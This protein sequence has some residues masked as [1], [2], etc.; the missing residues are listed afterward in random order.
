MEKQPKEKNSIK[1][2]N[3][4]N[5]EIKDID[6]RD[7]LE[8]ANEILAENNYSQVI[9]KTLNILSGY[10]VADK[11]YFIIGD[12]NQSNTRIEYGYNCDKNDIINFKSLLIKDCKIIP[13]SLLFES[14]KSG[15]IISDVFPFKN[16][17]IGNNNYIVSNNIQ[18][19]VVNPISYQ[20]VVIGLLYAESE[21]QES[22]SKNF[23]ELIRLLSNSIG[24]AI[25]K[26]I[27]LKT[28]KKS[29]E[30][31]RISRQAQENY[32]ELKNELLSN[33]S[34]EL[35]T[36]LNGII[37]ITESLMKGN[38]GQLPG[39]VEYNLSLI[40]S[41]GKQLSFIANDILDFSVLDTNEIV[42]RKKPVDLGKISHYVAGLSK[43]LIGEKKIK[44]KNTID[45]NL[46]FVFGDENKL[47]FVLYDLVSNAVKYTQSGE[48]STSAIVD[49]G[50]VIVSVTDTGIGIPSENLDT[51]FKNI[52]DIKEAVKKEGLTGFSLAIDKYLVELHKG[53]IWAES[54]E[55][56]GSRFSFSIPVFNEELFNK[57]Y[58]DLKPFETP[59]D[60]SSESEEIDTKIIQ[61]GIKILVVDDEPIMA[62]LIKNYFNLYNYNIVVCHDGLTALQTIINN[63]DFD[64]IVLDVM[65]PKMSGLDVARQI[66]QNYSLFE[67]PILIL[68]AR[69]QIA[70]LVEGFEAGA[71]DY[72]LKPFDPNEL[73]ARGKTLIKLRR[74]T[75]V[76]L[77][78]Q[79][80]IELK[81]Q[82][83]NMTV[84]DLK[85]PLNVIQGISVMLKDLPITDTTEAEMIDLIHESSTLMSNLIN[86]LLE[87]ASLES[88]KIT[89]DR[90]IID[91]NEV[92]EDIITGNQTR[93]D[94]KKQKLILKAGPKDKCH[95]NADN[96]RIYEILDN[97][98]NNAIKYSPKGKNI[99]ISISHVKEKK[100]RFVRCEV[101]DEGPGLTQEDMK[102][103]FGKFQRLSAQPTGGESSTGLGLSIVKQLV[104]LHDGRIW[105]ESEYGK[106]TSF[107]VEFP[108]KEKE[109]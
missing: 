95:I 14:L 7:Y 24:I 89:I 54:E 43:I 82:F 107:I 99:Q 71:N 1:P 25:N 106:G 59:L 83:I 103:L 15:K 3:A 86:E 48:I 76:N 17:P 56:K 104:E 40:S 69:N 105:A 36:R 47:Q 13:D 63:P 60:T 102:R 94:N 21:S 23:V 92:A 62:Q 79:Q 28:I 16:V 70:D 8:I 85:N 66:R 9:R 33:I 12:G 53:K 57:K 18:W 27:N 22:F 45:K 10:N 91:L 49:N 46:P 39:D 29:L 100:I 26:A 30:Q 72:L 77:I 108:A 32:F 42:V 101:K 5:T 81:N 75:K 64:L 34:L 74:L 109:T 11:I 65:M 67:L 50:M 4:V 96:I 6:E 87:N 84:H 20:K 41:A 78:L 80:A 35:N 44:F 51:L 97:L 19:V 52:S 2:F 93:A 38:I 55:N 31:E 58:Q 61:Q 88:G 73:I 37:G 98:V 90:K 68:T